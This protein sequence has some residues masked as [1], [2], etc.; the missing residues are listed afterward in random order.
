MRVDTYNTCEGVAPGV[1]YVTAEYC[2]CGGICGCTS[3]AAHTDPYEK[4]KLHDK[5]S[6]LTRHHHRGRHLRHLP[7]DFPVIR[8]GRKATLSSDYH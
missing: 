4:G 3:A 5:Q 2:T 7:V 6:G 1:P 8:E